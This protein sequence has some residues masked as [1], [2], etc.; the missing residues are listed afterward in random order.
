MLPDTL[1]LSFV[2]GDAG[3]F[4]LLIISA[5]IPCQEFGFCPF[6]FVYYFVPLCLFTAFKHLAESNGVPGYRNVFKFIF[7]P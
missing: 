6:V 1:I 5:N 2:Q 3:I 7:V 4:A